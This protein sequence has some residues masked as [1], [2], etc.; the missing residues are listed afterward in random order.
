MTCCLNNRRVRVNP[1]DANT[2]FLHRE[3][4]Y[5]AIND[6]DD[7]ADYYISVPTDL[8]EKAAIIDQMTCSI[9][10]ICL[11]DFFMSF[12]YCF[13]KLLSIRIFA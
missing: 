8:L 10:F 1:G 13:Y 3:N 12:Y 6:V 2:M 9:R 5:A 4:P 11:C 7:D